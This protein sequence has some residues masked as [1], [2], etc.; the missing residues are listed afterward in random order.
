[1]RIGNAAR[2]AIVIGVLTA[3]GS[4]HAG[5]GTPVT[6][7]GQWDGFGGTYADIWGDG[8]FAYIGHFGHDAVDIID[9]S[10]PGNLVAVTYPLSAPNQGAS[11]QDVKVG[12][13][14]MFI[15]LSGGSE[16]IEI[17]DVRDPMN[18]VYVG[19]IDIP[20]YQTIHNLFYDSGWIYLA[21][22]STARV[23]IVDL[24]TFDPDNP[25]ASPITAT[26]WIVEN[27]G[28]SR[29]HDI[30]VADGRLYACGW[31]SGLWI[32]DV[33][34]VATEIPTFLG[35]TPGNNT[36]S[37]WP[38]AA[39]DYVVTGEERSGG[40]IQVYRITDNG[41]SVTLDL[42]D[43]LALPTNQA[44]SVHNQLIV[45]YRVYNS[46]YGAGLLIHDIDPV[47]GLL[48]EVAIFNPA[49]NVWGVYPFL[50]P[51]RVLLSN[52]ASGLMV[53]QVGDSPLGDIDG[54][55]LVGITDFLMLLADW[56]PCD[57]PCP[58]QCAADLDGDC[59]VGINDFLLLLANWSD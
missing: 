14:L 39:G 1:M 22:S 57:R 20:G 34:N 40:G 35:S 52:M 7:I 43:S 50:G 19:S 58:P 36:H 49:G 55:G 4:A 17:V 5:G 21:D 32:Y 46:W 31:D 27:V 44:S 51:G 28:T 10:D 30:T 59:N 11:A 6:L 56:G 48:A 54:D 16:S 8:N 12:D 9:I 23:G 18:P 29:V 38:T 53:L 15:G 45:G 42:T 13:G 25:P 47:T 41:G 24:R 2:H 3:C 33:T 37:A 26:T